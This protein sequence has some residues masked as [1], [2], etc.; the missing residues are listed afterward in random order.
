MNVSWIF[1]VPIP[2][3]PTFVNIDVDLNACNVSDLI[4]SNAWDDNSRML[5]FHPNL[6]E[7]IKKLGL[8]PSPDDDTWAWAVE[9]DGSVTT[10]SAYSFLRSRSLNDHSPSVSWSALW[11]FKLPPKILTFL[12]KLLHNR[13]PTRAY[14]H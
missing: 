6:W 4:S 9:V 12:W 11:K 13:L 7:S 3:K 8:P 10:S 14:L 2:L 1:D 5:L